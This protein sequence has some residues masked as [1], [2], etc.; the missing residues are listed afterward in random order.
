LLRIQLKL[1]MMYLPRFVESNKTTPSDN[2]AGHTMHGGL[3]S[4][5]DGGASFPIAAA[6]VWHTGAALLA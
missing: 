4:A 2:G 5:L 3:V 1:C 6:S